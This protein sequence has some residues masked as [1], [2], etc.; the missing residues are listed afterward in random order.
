MSAYVLLGLGQAAQAGYA[1]DATL[2]Q[3]A[4][5]HIQN[6]LLAAQNLNSQS[7]YNRYVFMQ[8]ALQ[9]SGVPDHFSGVSVEDWKAS[10]QYM[11]KLSPW[12]EALLALGVKQSQPENSMAGLIASDLIS[13]VLRTS[14]GISWV[15]GQPDQENLSSPNFNTGVVVYALSQLSVDAATVNEAAHY[16]VVHQRSDGGWNSTYESAWVLMGLSEAMIQN[17]DLKANYS[18]STLLNNQLVMVTQPDKVNYASTMEQVIPFNQLRLTFPNMLT[19][20]RGAGNGRLFYR[21][22]LKVNQPAETAQ[23]LEKGLTLTRRY[24]L[25]GQDCPSFPCPT[26]TEANLENLKSP[27]TVH[28]SLVVPNPMYYVSVEDTVPAGVEIINLFL[29]TTRQGVEKQPAPGAGE[30]PFANGWN[31]WYF[32]SPRIGD[33]TV[34]WVAEQVPAGIYEL[35]Y[36]IHPQI[37]GQFHILPAHAYQIYYPEVEA[38]S[39]GAMLN[40]QNE[41]SK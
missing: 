10:Y 30:D 35:T 5:Q 29:N 11:D 32:G 31:A 15:E 13:K 26:V 27:L 2:L 4:Q 28:L 21:I 25:S 41:P 34:S 19:I 12:A 3:K 37:A 16:L 33:H 9:S 22:F 39:A 18:F 20:N 14:S 1:V 17:N 23:P 36:Q 7:A 6:S 24:E 38:S 40:I 8:F